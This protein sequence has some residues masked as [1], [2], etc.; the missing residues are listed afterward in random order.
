MEI[1]KKTYKYMS[2]ISFTIVL[3]L[4]I[5]LIVPVFTNAEDNEEGNTN[6]EIGFDTETEKGFIIVN[7]TIQ[8]SVDSYELYWANKEYTNPKPDADASVEEKKKFL[9]ETENWFKNDE[10]KIKDCVKINNSSSIND[11]VE[12]SR[13]KSYS[14]LCIVHS[15]DST[16]YNWLS[17][18]AEKTSEPVKDTKNEQTEKD[19][20]DYKVYRITDKNYGDI[21]IDV[22]SKLGI[23]KAIKY[24]ISDEN[25]ELKDNE[26]TKN[27]I[28]TSGTPM[29]VS[30]EK[31]NE[32][33]SKSDDEVKDE[34]YITLYVET[35]VER[36]EGSETFY[37]YYPLGKVS[38]LEKTECSPWD[39]I[40]IP[41]EI[42]EDETD[43]QEKANESTVKEETKQE[44]KK[45]ETK[46]EEQVDDK[47]N[48]EDNNE[49]KTINSIGQILEIAGR[50]KE[51]AEKEIEKQKKQLENEEKAK[52]VA[53]TQEKQEVKTEI[54]ANQDNKA[55][56]TTPA[57]QETKTKT[58]TS[59]KQETKTLTT[60]S[61]KQDTT[62]V[63][64]NTVIPQTGSNDSFVIAGIILFS[65]IGVIGLIKYKK[66]Q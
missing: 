16:R 64:N 34:K 51:E 62:T 45:E 9:V 1:K 43:N 54:P 3:M 52:E 37:F 6:V 25:I 38:D 49:P 12:Y 10:N 32:Q 57:K 5:N 18:S 58:T 19:S 23:I 50:E 56:A 59:A 8:G 28:K 13:E 21:A 35:L 63:S 17:L 44:E 66:E 55:Q 20:I 22:N 47:D 39:I 33:I 24:Y 53:K 2:I 36:T 40:E 46:Q 42:K 14:V 27:T 31:K 41:D 48:N 4:V 7:G 61:T 60:T 11:K 15:S 26:E 30:G 29:S 65:I